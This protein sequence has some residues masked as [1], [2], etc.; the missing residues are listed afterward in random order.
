M[1]G[2]SHFPASDWEATPIKPVN[3]KF[4]FKYFCKVCHQ[5]KSWK[6]YVTKQG[7]NGEKKKELKWDDME[8]FCHLKVGDEDTGPTPQQTSEY[9]CPF[10]K[11]TGRAI[12][13][14]LWERPTNR[15]GEMFFSCIDG[16]IGG[17]Q[18]NPKVAGPAPALRTA[19]PTTLPK[20]PSTTSAPK[21]SVSAADSPPEKKEEDRNKVEQIIELA[22]SLMK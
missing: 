18:A 9:D 3:G 7:W 20:A 2:L 21:K 13:L 14:I 17:A 16:I 12:I 15:S 1:K 22:E 8:E 10:P 11:T 4:H 19:K 5:T 6:A